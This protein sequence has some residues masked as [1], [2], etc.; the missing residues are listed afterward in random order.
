MEEFIERRGIRRYFVPRETRSGRGR[1]G[2]WIWRLLEMGENGKGE[3]MYTLFV[4][5][6]T[7]G[8]VPDYALFLLVGRKIEGAG[9]G[10]TVWRRERRSSGRGLFRG[11]A[12]WFDAGFRLKLK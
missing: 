10:N 1:V 2:G 9:Y 6:F 7:E 11:L 12:L 8:E 4:G 3:G 5:D